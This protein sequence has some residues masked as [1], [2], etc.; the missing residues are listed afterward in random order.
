MGIKARLI[1]L[2]AGMV[3]ALAAGVSQMEGNKSIPYR[4]IGGVWT[5]CVGDTHEVDPSHKYT[6]QECQDRLVSQLEAHN[7]GLIQCMPGLANSPENVHAAILDLGYNVGVGAVCRSSIPSKMK[8][9]DYRAACLTIGEFNKAAGRDCRIKANNCY[10]IVKRRDWD[11]AL[12]NGEL[13]P[14][15]IAKGYAGYLESRQ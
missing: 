5:A 2:S 15:Q 1:G 6:Q 12:C 10:G 11:V 8:S 9:G 4:D 3:V 14:E 13:T 7:N